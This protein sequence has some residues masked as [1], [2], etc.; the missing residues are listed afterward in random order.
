MVPPRP[1]FFPPCFPHF[2]QSSTT[3]ISLHSLTAWTL[4]CAYCSVSSVT[5]HLPPQINLFS[6]CD[7]TDCFGFF[8]F[9]SLS[10][11]AFN[12]HRRCFSNLYTTGTDSRLVMLNCLLTS[13]F[14]LEKLKERKKKNTRRI[15]VGC[16]KFQK[17]KLIQVESPSEA[18][19]T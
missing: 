19:T 1:P 12:T 10:C 14:H 4:C 18:D 16:R 15:S 17:E 8:F 2:L 5:P 9:L 7:I 13:V 11:S 3:L 6:I